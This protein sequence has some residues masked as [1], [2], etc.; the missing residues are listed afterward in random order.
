MS[1]PNE[2][3]E[4]SAFAPASV[5]NVAC[6]FDVLGFAVHGTGDVVH[7][8][9]NEQSGVVIESITGDEGRLPLA[10][11]ENTA[12]KAVLALLDALDRKPEHGITLRIEKQM[13]LGSGLGSSAASAVAAVMAAN[14]LLGDPFTKEELLPFALAGEMVASG[15][16]H[17]DNIA[18]SLLGGFVLVRSSRPLDVVRLPVPDELVAAVIHPHIEINTKSAREML[19]KKVFLSDAVTQ[20]GNLGALVAAL[21]RSDYDLLARSLVDVIIEP[22]RSIL[23]PEFD[24]MKQRALELGVLGFTISGA[25]PSVFALCRGEEIAE[26]VVQSAAELLSDAGVESDGFVSAINTEGSY[27]LN[28]EQT[29]AES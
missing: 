2:R 29:G 28:Q 14:E 12:G 7:A 4:T 15:S 20:W 5:S 22:A 19:K 26:K 25:G 27:C 13:P 6:G 10:A 1:H 9:H 17:A 24:A 16:A 23:I 18:P 8:R 3:M 11:E 21:Y